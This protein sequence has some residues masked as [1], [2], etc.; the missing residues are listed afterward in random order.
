[1][2]NSYAQ[3]FCRNS[4]SLDKKGPGSKWRVCNLLD[5]GPRRYHA[6]EYVSRHGNEAL[7]VDGNGK[8]LRY[9]LGYLSCSKYS[10]TTSAKTTRTCVA[11]SRK[12]SAH[13]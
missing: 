6:V 2:K 3:T 1:M 9:N 12:V 8:P 4:K 5:D 10:T 11:Y 7:F 13:V